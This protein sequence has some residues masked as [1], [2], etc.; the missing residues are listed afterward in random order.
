M[1]YRYNLYYIILTRHICQRN[2]CFMFFMLND[3][4]E[5][6]YRVS[7]NIWFDTSIR[8]Y[9]HF[10]DYSVVIKYSCNRAK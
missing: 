10:V 3:H 2:E 8:F 9:N 4:A 1:I 7:S 5:L 6:T